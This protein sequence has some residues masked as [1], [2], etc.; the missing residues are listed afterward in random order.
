MGHRHFTRWPT[1]EG[2]A[3]RQSVAAGETVEIHCS[4]RVPSV[5]VE[6]ARLGTER[7]VVW[8][9]T[10]DVGDHPVPDDAWRIGL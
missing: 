6:V 4:S 3:A 10:V 5:D 8:R 7:N 1:A 9:P 2:Y